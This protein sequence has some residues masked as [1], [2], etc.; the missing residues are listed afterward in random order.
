MRRRWVAITATRR[1]AYPA[2]L[3][4]FGLGGCTANQAPSTPTIAPDEWHR[5]EQA[6]RLED[7]GSHEAAIDL[8]RD[9]VCASPRFVSAHRALQN[10]EIA[11]H[12]RGELLVRYRALLNAE[13]GSAERWYLWGRIQT[14]TAAQ[15]DAF[16]QAQRLDP[17]CPWPFL[18]LGALAL[19][20]QQPVVA[21]DLFRQ[22]HDL[23]P[24]I[25]DF[26]LGFVR[27]LL[28]AP[29]LFEVG[30]GLLAGALEEEPWSVER[31]L[32]TSDYFERAGRRREALELLGRLLARVPRND[33]VARRLL[34]RLE[35]DG[36]VDDVLWLTHELEVA[37][38][39]PN[40]AVVLARCHA[41][42]GDAVA[43]IAA[44]DAMPELAA[45]QY[46]S[47]RLLLV[48]RGEPARALALEAPR[49]RALAAVGAPTVAYDAACRIAAAGAADGALDA[50]AL[51]ATFRDLGWIEEA[52]ALLRPARRGPAH[53]PAADTLLG[54]LLCQ[55]QL[56]AELKVATLET[57]RRQ[58]EGRLVPDLATFRD[59]VAAATRR[60]TGLDLMAEVVCQ[61]F[62]PLGELIDPT[63]DHGLPRWF[64]DG[65]RLLVIGQRRGQPPE[66][67]LAPILARARA[68][69]QDAELFFVEGT[70]I[71]GWLEQQGA[72]FAGAAL[73]RFVWIDVA[74]VEDD[75]ARLLALEREV[76]G[77]RERVLADPIEHAV[78]RRARLAIDEPGEVATKLELRALADWRARDPASDRAVLLAE[79]LDAVLQH[80]TGHLEDAQR[81]LPLSSK[82]W[83]QLPTLFSLG[84]SAR[85]IEEWLEM[86]AE[87]CALVR[88]RN[89]YLVLAECT[90]Q[91][92]GHTTLTPHGDGYRELLDR[93]VK[94]IDESLAA[95]PGLD[96]T[97]NL[98]QQLD[99]LTSDEVRELARR[100]LADLGIET[101]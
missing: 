53:D 72:H 20:E 54:Q 2:A 83:S 19:G 70:L 36:T 14:S 17:R 5:L 81:F 77:K 85:R 80:E 58:T 9:I 87:C 46:A 8:L 30:G 18:G 100:V 39:E 41:M 99:R 38:D 16:G 57:Y 37:A 4:L 91:L 31:V 3:L 15:R 32:L 49:F 28:A 48:L 86:R 71:P 84:F 78:D 75:V 94:E 65:G 59:Q 12:R 61:S 66:L 10:L 82:I 27:G 60:A 24:A 25:P 13:P 79:S 40:V 29:G 50:V 21:L 11:D 97:R 1:R 45:E 69:P 23:Q 96:P 89:P 34:E 98:L 95:Y 43:A 90:S 44:W 68:G 56:E 22:A 6:R 62:W 101:P 73:D 26:E 35:R 74:A 42:R 55:R 7:V 51:A 64:R 63:V 67:F 76:G 33:E 88:A 52:I 47:R 93:L 92:S